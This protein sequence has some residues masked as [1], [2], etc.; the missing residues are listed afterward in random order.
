MAQPKQLRS[1]LQPERLIFILGAPRSGTTWLAKI[2]DSHPD[3]LYRHEPDATIR[4][5]SFPLQCEPADVAGHKEAARAYVQRLLD[6]RVPKTAGT[7]PVFPKGY[8]GAVT[9]RLRTAMVAAL[10]TVNRAP[11]ISERS[12]NIAIPDLFVPERYPAL[13][14]VIKSV[15]SLGRAGLF[16]ETLPGSRFVLIVRH[17]C[18]YI[19]S[20][21]RGEAHGKFSRRYPAHQVLGTSHAA[22]YGLT[23][24]RFN[25]LSRPEQLAWNWVINYEKA[26]GDLGTSAAKVK[27]VRY[28]DLGS[29]P[30]EETKA[31]FAFAGLPWSAQTEA[32]IGK[33]T[34]HQGPDFYYGVLKDTNQVVNRWRSELSPED[35]RAIMAVVSQTTLADL[36][37]AADEALSVGEA[38]PA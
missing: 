34:S 37:P 16:A 31:L 7:W 5:F 1:A 9:S 27:L 17:P 26:I 18:G 35:Q 15:S 23:E 24:E 10:R 28:E 25:A 3:V 11:V 33:S 8:Y 22:R 36:F 30:L 13:R 19:A 29:R 21:L 2:F 14:T 6:V 12:K 20:T 4:D 38:A 32:F